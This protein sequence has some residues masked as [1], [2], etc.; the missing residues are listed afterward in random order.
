MGYKDKASGGSFNLAE[1]ADSKMAW[2][3]IVMQTLFRTIE[4]DLA[5]NKKA[6]I[7]GVK[8]MLRLLKPYI[9]PTTSKEIE[10]IFQAHKA[11]KEKIDKEDGTPAQLDTKRLNMDYRFYDEIMVFVHDSLGSS[12]VME[13]EIDGILIYDKELESLNKYGSAVRK[14]I[15]IKEVTRGDHLKDNG[16]K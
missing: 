2:K 7:R 10:T 6:Y 1:L 9:S 13:H 11:E 4:S 15:P 16:D 3:I 8:N 12:P 5:D 14:T